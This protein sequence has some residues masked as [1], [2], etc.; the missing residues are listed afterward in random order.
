[1]NEDRRRDAS[2]E[3]S[4]RRQI[5]TDKKKR[6]AIKRQKNYEFGRKSADELVL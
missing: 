4:L 6:G 5:G 1:M 2:C 3:D